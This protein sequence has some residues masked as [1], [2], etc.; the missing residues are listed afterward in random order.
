MHARSIPVA[1]IITATISLDCIRTEY[2]K[3]GVVFGK[4]VASSLQLPRLQVLEMRRKSVIVFH[5][6]AA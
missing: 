1:Q 5:V 3:Y 2:N 6:G 4:K